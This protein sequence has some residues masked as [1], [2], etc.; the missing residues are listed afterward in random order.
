MEACK[1]GRKNNNLHSYRELVMRRNLRIGGTE[2]RTQIG[3]E[4]VSPEATTTLR[5]TITPCHRDFL[6]FPSLNILYSIQ[7]YWK[8]FV[9]EK[10]PS[11]ADAGRE[12]YS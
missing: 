7:P 10:A 8:H 2:N 4:F 11:S 3:T 5:A 12:Y 1:K 6:K 9:L